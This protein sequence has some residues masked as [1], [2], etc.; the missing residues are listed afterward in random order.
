MFAF[1]LTVIFLLG[2]GFYYSIKYRENKEAVTT[3]LNVTL[4]GLAFF[5]LII[6]VSHLYDMNTRIVEVKHELIN[7]SDVAELHR[8]LTKNFVRK[9]QEHVI[10]EPLPEAPTDFF[11]DRVSRIKD[12]IMMEKNLNVNEDQLDEIIRNVLHY[13]ELHNVQPTNVLAIIRYESTFNPK[14]RA[15]T[16]SAA[17]LMQVIARWHPEKV[18]GRDLT[19]I[20]VAID[21]GVQVL[22]EC[23]KRSNGDVLNALKCYRGKNDDKYFKN[24]M[25]Y[26]NKLDKHLLAMS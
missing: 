15:K 25:T 9:P 12:V 24:I 10:H 13:A 23:K 17:G 2:I 4:G 1:V 21:A 6:G 11:E 18:K 16:S 14:A 3:I 7:Y 5:G 8:A 19:K 20:D 26:K 22:A